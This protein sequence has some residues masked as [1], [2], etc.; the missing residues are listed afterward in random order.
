MD[1]SRLVIECNLIIET[2]VDQTTSSSK[3]NTRQWG[4]EIHTSLYF[5]WSKRAWEWS[6]LWMGSEIRKPSNLKSGQMDAILSKMNIQPFEN[7]IIWNLT[8]K[9]SGFQMVRF[10]IL[11]VFK[12]AVVK[13]FRLIR[14]VRQ[15]SFILPWEETADIRRMARQGVEECGAG[16]TQDRADEKEQEDK[17]V[18]RM[19]FL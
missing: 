10:Q 12:S 18:W 8:L 1:N 6:V 4:S 16:Q 3:L 17:F 11:T 14:E 2:F 7:K 19:D 5:K 9:K 13:K 15:I